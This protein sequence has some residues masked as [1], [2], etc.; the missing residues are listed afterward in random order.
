MWRLR[1]PQGA[2][3]FVPF[4]SVQFGLFGM[5]FNFLQ[6]CATDFDALTVVET[7]WEVSTS[8]YHYRRRMQSS[9]AIESTPTWSTWS[10][11]VNLPEKLGLPTDASEP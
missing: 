5:A 11:M 7:G 4:S 2:L 6:H 9:R 8:H 1:W 3:R 10:T